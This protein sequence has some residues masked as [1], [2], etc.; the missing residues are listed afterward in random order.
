MLVINPPHRFET[1]APP[2]LTALLDRLGAREPGE[3]AE[4]IRLVDE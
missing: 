4:M 3:G 2:I 1:D